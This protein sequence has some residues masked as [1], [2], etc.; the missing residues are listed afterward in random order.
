MNFLDVGATPVVAASGG[1]NTG[2]LAMMLA[3]LGL[4]DRHYDDKD[5]HWMAMMFL[6]IVFVIIIIVIIA[7]I[8]SKR[9][10]HEPALPYAAATLIPSALGAYAD[11]K[12]SHE[13]WD[14]LRDNA[15]YAYKT[16]E[17]I[18]QGKYESA[19]Q[20]ERHNNE[21]NR[22]I[23]QLRFDTE[24]QKYEI[25][26]NS[27]D[28]K[29]ATLQEKL[30]EKAMESNTNAIKN[31]IDHAL[32]SVVNTVAPRPLPVNALWGQ[33]PIA[34]SVPTFAPSC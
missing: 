33:V 8:W 26:S 4:K 12:A 24:R 5:D 13:H 19:M 16:Q 22:N 30:L 9:E 11:G 17:D 23:D 7:L 31:Y 25:I 15:E 34:A 28:D 10:R 32:V 6:F 3:M 29:I 27:K 2:I 18:L 14:A 21:T 1:D 20:A